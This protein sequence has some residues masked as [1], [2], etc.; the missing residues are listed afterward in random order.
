M[1]GFLERGRAYE[2]DTPYSMHGAIASWFLGPQS[3]NQNRLQDYFQR[4]LEFQTDARMSFHPEDGVGAS[5]SDL[6]QK[7]TMSSGF[8][9]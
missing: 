3:E 9:H 4:A 5:P 6:L 7:L 2:D 1:D 8:Y